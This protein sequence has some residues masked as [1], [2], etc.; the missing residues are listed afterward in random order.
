M[1]TNDYELMVKPIISMNPQANAVLERVHQ[2]IGNII[3]TF[4]VQNM[5][6]EEKNQWDG[7]LASTM[8]AQRTTIHTATLYTPAKLIFGRDSIINQRHNVDRETIRK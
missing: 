3:H 8:F 5:V 2:A 6:L 7:I 4:K 1:I